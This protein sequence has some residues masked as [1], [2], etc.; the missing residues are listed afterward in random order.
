MNR[1][2]GPNDVGRLTLVLVGIMSLLAGLLV[3]IAVSAT[4]LAGL[5]SLPGASPHALFVVAWLTIGPI[6]IALLAAAAAGRL[7]HP[8]RK[9]G[10]RADRRS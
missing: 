5:A 3:A 6:V 2:A 7:P 1:A 4:V 9:A 10:T 8:G